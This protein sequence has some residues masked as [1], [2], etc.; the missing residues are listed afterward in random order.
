MGG[1]FIFHDKI[2]RLIGLIGMILNS[3]IKSYPVEL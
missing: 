1:V 2:P 3:L